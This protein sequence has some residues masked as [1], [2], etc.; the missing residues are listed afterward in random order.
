MSASPPV[1]RN[2][3]PKPS[4]YPLAW[5]FS[6]VVLVLWGVG[7][8]VQNLLGNPPGSMMRHRAILW[9][10]VDAASWAWI[11]FSA[12]VLAHLLSSNR[13]RGAALATSAVLLACVRLAVMA[14]LGK[15]FVSDAPS[16]PVVVLSYLPSNLPL[17][18]GLFGLA[19]SVSEYHARIEGDRL[20]SGLEAQLAEAELRALQMQLEPHFLF[21]ALNT[22]SALMRKDVAAADDVLSRLDELLST[23]LRRSAKQFVELRE[24]IGFVRHYLSIEQVRFRDRLRV[25]YSI[26]PRAEPVL[27]P[28]LVL[29][30]IVENAIKH[31]IA[32]LGRASELLVAASLDS[33]GGL[34]LEVRDWGVGLAQPGNRDRSR[35][36]GLGIAATRAR[37]EHLYG[38]TATLR[39][40]SPEGGG[41]RVVVRIPRRMS[42]GRVSRYDNGHP[43]VETA[44]KRLRALLREAMPPYLA[45]WLALFAAALSTPFLSDALGLTAFGARGIVLSAW[46]NVAMWALLSAPCLIVS[47]VYPVRRSTFV[48]P[49]V[50]NIACALGC[51]LAYLFVC[52]S[53][54][55]MPSDI[56]L[57][58]LLASQSGMLLLAGVAGF[59]HMLVYT[60]EAA[61]AER[62]AAGMRS[63]LANAELR[64]IKSRLDPDLIFGELRE[65]SN[66]MKRDVKAAD[67]WLRE[68]ATS[69]RGSLVGAGK[70]YSRL[71]DQLE[72][73]RLDLQTP[74]GYR[75]QHPALEIDLNA[76]AAEFLLPR[77]AVFE[78]VQSLITD[79]SSSIRL[80]ARTRDA[81]GRLV[82][83]LLLTEIA[84]FKSKRTREAVVLEVLAAHFGEDASADVEFDTGRIRA[85]LTMPPMDLPTPADA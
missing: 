67:R 82:V 32:P 74:N 77:N 68:L 49:L 39:M 19:Y 52:R 18:L 79:R 75:K 43:G 46:F 65:V 15:Q 22:V 76:P 38:S 11:W 6:V 71:S 9:G 66:L 10:V 24:E 55:R 7:S 31:G 63:L 84:G 20:T 26:D 48:V 25:R 41:T 28:H 70:G 60:R 30:P 59:G 5:A 29:Q 14:E 17:S 34:E 2:P 61:T 57:A 58:A 33:K 4:E 50:V 3:F 53:A 73:L 8:S 44:G 13:F 69:L 1:A 80:R 42:A 12:L 27:V 62:Y 45:L 72:L 83:D 21:N 36:L 51:I 81:D 23:S 35:S 64:S 54:G 85:T 47:I 78:A 37:L 56:R 40:E 16:L